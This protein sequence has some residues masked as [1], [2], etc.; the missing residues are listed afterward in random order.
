MQTE[1]QINNEHQ[2]TPQSLNEAVKA[3][4]LD[5]PDN[6]LKVQQGIELL[7]QWLKESYYPKKDARLAQLD[8]L[9]LLN[10]VIDV[11]VCVAHCIGPVL[12]VSVTSKLAA[13]MGFNNHRDSIITIAEIV[14]VLCET[15]A[16]DIIKAD[17]RSSLMLINRL[18]LPTAVIER[19][20][21]Q[22]YLPPLV[23]KPKVVYSNYESAYLTF[24]D[25]L[26]LGSN[27]GHNEDICLDVINLQNSI[28]LEL[29]IPFLESVPETPT[30][31]LDTTDKNKQW[32]VFTKQS[33]KIYQML[34][35]QGNEFYLANKV[36]KRGR[37]YA[38]G[39]HVTTQGS[40]FKKAMIELAN[41]E[42]V[43]GVTL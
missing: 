35:D 16:F 5:D 43:E 22:H 7:K 3:A 36:D 32:K 20:E 18:N 38:S 9:S 40:P 24:N 33:E 41:K 12:Y 13:K 26:I 23:C 10:I 28:P 1:L 17:A 31:T 21:N 37:M 6:A 11:F 25:S 39:Y 4:I 30:H 29:H 8:P 42:L 2:F 27:N 19:I 14:A 34:H 15:D